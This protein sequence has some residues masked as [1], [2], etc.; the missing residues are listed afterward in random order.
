M[1]HGGSGKEW[2]DR[3]NLKKI[4]IRKEIKIISRL[5]RGGVTNRRS[6]QLL[7]IDCIQLSWQK[8]I[9]PRKDIHLPAN[10][11][12]LSWGI[13]KY[14]QEAI[15]KDGKRPDIDSFQ[16]HC[17]TSPVE[18]QQEYPYLAPGSSC[19]CA[20]CLDMDS[21]ISAIQLPTEVPRHYPRNCIIVANS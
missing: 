3:V 7:N 21:T 11:D 15:D 20:T 1:L 4:Y 10:S 17:T 12:C 13:S 14:L 16:D 8:T 19:A 2:S 9:F 18:A 6:H 5:I